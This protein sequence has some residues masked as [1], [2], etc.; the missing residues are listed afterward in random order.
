[1]IRLL[2]ESVPLPSDFQLNLNTGAAG[3]YGGAAP[4]VSLGTLVGSIIS[5]VLSLLGVIFLCLVLYAGF[6][7]MTA[8]GDPKAITKAKEILIGGVAGMLIVLSAYAITDFV[9]TN[10]QGA[11]AVAPFIH[12]TMISVRDI[13]FT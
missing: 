6:L 11:V 8:Q 2:A 10:L 1:M 5:G 9:T 7:W 4:S 3:A 12:S 13:L